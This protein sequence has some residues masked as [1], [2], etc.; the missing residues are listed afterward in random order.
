MEDERIIKKLT[1]I[2]TATLLAFGFNLFI[3]ENANATC[4]NHI[5][6][7]TIAAAYQGDAEPTVH[8]MDTCSGD[9]IGYQIP[10][11]TTVTFDGVQ[12]ENIYATTNSVIT[13]GQPDPTYWAYPNT[14]SISLY[15]MDWFPGVSGTSGLDIYYS[16]GGFQLNLNMVPFGNY[17]AQPSTVN[18]LVAITNT[19]NLAVSYSYQGPEYPNLRTGV[20]LHN[21]DIVSLEAWGATQVSASEPVPVL[22]AE[23]IPE[24]SPTPTQQPSPE[25][26]PTPTEAPITPEEQ[27]EQVAEAAQLAGEISDLNNLIASINGEEVNEP[28]PTPD[29]EPSPDSTEDPDLPEPDVEVEPEIITP[30]DPRFP[31]D[32]Q[33]EPED[34]TPSPS[35]DTTDGDSE[36]TDP[37]PEPSE[38]PTPQPEETDTGQESEPEQPVDE[39]PVVPAPDNNTDDSNPISADELKKLNKLIGQND[40]KLAAEL[41]N[42]LTE[43]SPKEE[44]AIAENLGIKAEEVA[45][46]AEAIKDNPAI[47]VAFVEFAGRA[48]ENADAPMPYT[49]ADAI[50][51]VQTE[52]FLADPLGV[53]T[54]IDFEKLLSPTEWGKDM[55]DDQR[56]KV[57]EVV[58]PVILVGNIV[59]S[60]MSLRRL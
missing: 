22:Q 35:P 1:R 36:E 48:E 57:Q 44:E 46:I 50:T 49:L 3:P 15:S 4:I 21:G 17:G 9:D 60:V 37:T 20:R 23:P 16:E 11:A 29:P 13:F 30:E 52:A 7:Q 18:I 14:P 55:T 33:T 19:G 28:E 8:H 39:E 10:I 58:I 34:I 41:S 26:S 53:L 27:Q 51:E 40:A 38:E 5:Q 54:N 43:L 32:E 31:D 2:L 47:A 24:P 6:S 12:Y 42:M 45:I 59:S 56:E 25:P